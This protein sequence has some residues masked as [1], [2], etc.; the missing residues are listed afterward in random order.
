MG[1]YTKTFVLIKE[2]QVDF[3]PSILWVPRTKLSCQL[4]RQAPLSP[5][6]YYV[7]ATNKNRVKV[8]GVALC[9][10]FIY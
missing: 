6:P 3:S 7:W 5:A 4:W 9:N 8:W 2:Q 10:P 1:G